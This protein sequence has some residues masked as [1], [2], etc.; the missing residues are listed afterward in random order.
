MLFILLA[1]MKSLNVE[2]IYILDN[3]SMIITS[4]DYD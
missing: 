4:I 3:V 1:T 2:I